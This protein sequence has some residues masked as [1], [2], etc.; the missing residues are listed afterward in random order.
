MQDKV[1]NSKT[2]IR[3]NENMKIKLNSLIETPKICA[4][5]IGQIQKEYMALFSKDSTTVLSIKPFLPHYQSKN[6]SMVLAFSSDLEAL[7]VKSS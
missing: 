6:N 5:K 7:K 1:K 3:N 4:H 2:K